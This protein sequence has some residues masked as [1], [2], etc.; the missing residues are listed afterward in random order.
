[1][2]SES[3]DDL[4]ERVD[5]LETTVAQ[6]R[7][8]QT[9]TDE[10]GREWTVGDIVGEFGMTRRQAVMVLGLVAGG[11]TLYQAFA[12]TVEAGT[13][14]VGTIGADGSRV[15]LF[16]E[17]I[18][19][20]SVD[21]T[22][23][24]VNS[25]Q[26]Q[27]SL[28]GLV[29][30]IASGVGANDAI[31]PS[32]TTT[33]VQDAIN[34]ISN[35]GVP[36]VVQIPPSTVQEASSVTMETGISVTGWDWRSS[37]IEFTDLSI[38][39]LVFDSA[40]GAKLNNVR[41]DG[42]DR[43]N[44]TGGSAARFIN[45]GT[46]SNHFRGVRFTNWINPVIHFDTGHPFSSHWSEIVGESNTTRGNSGRFLAAEDSAG[47][48]LTIANAYLGSTDA[49]PCME[50]READDTAIT[51]MGVGIQAV[52]IG[53]STTTVIDAQ[54]AAN[55]TLVVHD[56]TWFGDGGSPVVKLSGVGPTIL[57]TL[58][59]AGGEVP[60][61]VELA[62]AN[63]NNVIGPIDT[64]TTTV[65]NTKLDISSTPSDYS[66]YFGASDDVTN[67]AGSSTGNVRSLSTAGTGNG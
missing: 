46:N 47:P 34:V 4:R 2:S 39:G 7:E 23:I 32:N 3:E 26:I 64:S 66:W 52:N 49:T 41:I 29:V 55:A 20:V 62:G 60:Y 28:D 22:D 15:D 56:V 17:D 21:T 65:T 11:A 51:D 18:D 10:A 13:A 24:S 43:S 61:V 63:G 19:A 5:Q 53:G 27:A 37:V 48:G 58:R 8:Q 33:P 38:D 9:V 25:A 1:M 6:L 42:S 16:A 54:T 30:P 14:E 44:R 31:N 57:S 40:F 59:A 36:G 67:N 50:F 12:R 35:A 45:G